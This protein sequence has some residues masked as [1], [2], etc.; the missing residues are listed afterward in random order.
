MWTLKTVAIHYTEFT[1]SER[2]IC[3]RI[4]E[5]PQIVNNSIVVL[6]DLCETS[7]SAI[8][9]F[10]QKLDTVDTRIQIFC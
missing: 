6:G 10:Y 7:K 1:P 3:A 2:K 4:L 9:R 8:L 5:D